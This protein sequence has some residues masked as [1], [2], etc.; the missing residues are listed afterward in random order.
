L[1]KPP[2]KKKSSQ[3][4][5]DFKG[6]KLGSKR[7]KG[8]GHVVGAFELKAKIYPKQTPTKAKRFWVGG[9]DI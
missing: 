4:V 2:T 6:R 8:G 1:E 5:E 7:T 3:I 9:P